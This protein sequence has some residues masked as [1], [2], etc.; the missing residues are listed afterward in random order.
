MHPKVK[1][2]MTRTAREVQFTYFIYF[3]FSFFFLI[4]PL[5]QNPLIHQTRWVQ[6]VLLGRI[7]R[8]IFLLDFVY[9]F[10]LDRIVLLYI[11]TTMTY[12]FQCVVHSP[13]TCGHGSKSQINITAIMS[14]P[15]KWLLHGLGF[16]RISI[17]LSAL[18]RS[19]TP[20]VPIQKK[21]GKKKRRRSSS[22]KYFPDKNLLFSKSP[23]VNRAHSYWL[24]W[25]R[26]CCQASLATLGQKGFVWS[27][28]SINSLTWRKT[29][30]GAELRD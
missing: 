18:K 28:L 29:S 3:V 2:H 9:S 11:H 15:F 5:E 21:K 22:T 10:L 4:P 26:I 1:D 24:L 17:W 20:S 6:V 27:V 13:D 14:T 7:C 8:T 16:M 19:W 25:K 23:C 12:I 30:G